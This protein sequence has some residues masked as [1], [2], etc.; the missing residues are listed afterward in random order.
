MSDWT[1]AYEEALA[2]APADTFI[3]S[4]L[5]LIH[6]QFVDFEDNQDSIRIA[7]DERAWTLEHEAMAPLF[8]GKQKRYDPLAMDIRLPEQ[9]E[10]SF[11]TLELK[12]DNVPRS[13]W[14]YLQKAA[15]VRASATV[16]F[17]Q[18]VAVR[19][20]GTGTYAC[21]G[22]PDM[23]YDQLTMKV[24]RATQLQLSGTAGFVDLLNKAF[25]RRSFDRDSFPGLHGVST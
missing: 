24:V 6:P 23:I 22:P 17:R 12:L 5:E 16:I 25:P 7:L 8:G 19:D 13:I 15:R 20:L 1:T 10:T 21:D 9:S 2:S 14:P 4:G 18:W 11:G 3:I